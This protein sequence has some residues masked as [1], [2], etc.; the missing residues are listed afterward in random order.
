MN[1]VRIRLTNGCWMISRCTNRK[2][3]WVVG[4]WFAW[5]YGWMDGRMCAFDRVIHRK[6]NYVIDRSSLSLSLSLSLCVCV[7]LCL[8]LS[9]TTLFDSFIDS[10][11][12]R[13]IDWL[14]HALHVIP[15]ACLHA[16]LSLSVSLCTSPSVRVS[17]FMHI[18]VCTL[19]VFV[20]EG[21]V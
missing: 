2:H 6:F 20:A 16:R 14:I 11:N 18:S 12:H 13:L 1:D 19:V 21:R 10:F 3:W 5:M 15:C 7:C 9:L 8:S 4:L 17:P